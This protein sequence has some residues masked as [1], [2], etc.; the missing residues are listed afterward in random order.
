VVDV[1]P[2]A[3]PPLRR[4]H[5]HNLPWLCRAG[6]T[7]VVSGGLF[8]VA[9]HVA[10]H[11]WA[12]SLETA[13]YGGHV[14]VLVGMVIALAGVWSIPWQRRKTRPRKETTCS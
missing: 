4:A 6:A 11:F 10:D 12:R 8:D 1:A 7:L 5:I 9:C 13:E 3:A 14:A 2:G